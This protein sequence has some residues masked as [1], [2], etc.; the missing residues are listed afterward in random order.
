MFS[1][2]PE[3]LEGSEGRLLSPP[4]QHSRP[5]F[6]CHGAEC[7]LY[8]IFNSRFLAEK[9]LL[10]QMLQKRCLTATYGVLSRSLHV[11]KA[12]FFGKI[13]TFKVS[14]YLDLFGLYIVGC[15]WAFLQPKEDWL[16]RR[17]LDNHRAIFSPKH[18]LFFSLHP[19]SMLV[20]SLLSTIFTPISPSAAPPTRPHR[21]S[22]AVCFF[23]QS[24]IQ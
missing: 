14:R 21:I 19:L 10:C 12:F 24:Q 2:K 18:L 5:Y 17:W 3:D 13:S 1:T 23:H 20:K 4:F 9:R 16:A 6:G 11:E 8:N 22:V 15:F 7:S